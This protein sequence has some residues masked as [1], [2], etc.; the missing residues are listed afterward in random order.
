M[1][2]GWNKERDGV[3]NDLVCGGVKRKGFD[4]PG[5]ELKTKASTQSLLKSLN[6][7]VSKSSGLSRA[8][9]LTPRSGP[10]LG[11]GLSYPE[12]RSATLQVLHRQSGGP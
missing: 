8:S 1:R 4:E 5:V 2:R 11:R 6:R 10:H 3:C 12:A 9:H 7:V